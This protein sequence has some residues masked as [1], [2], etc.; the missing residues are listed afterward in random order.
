MVYV[1]FL[2]K[3]GSEIKKRFLLDN[4]R[5]K[6]EPVKQTFS[7][8]TVEIYIGKCFHYFEAIDFIFEKNCL[9]CFTLP[10]HANAIYK[11]F[12]FSCK[13]GKFHQKKL[14]LI[15]W[16]YTSNEYPQSVFWI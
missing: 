4:G 14:P 10:K 6:L 11:E 1:S 12:F 5:L 16:E 3:D 7:L 13:N 8:E 15:D 2:C 9:F